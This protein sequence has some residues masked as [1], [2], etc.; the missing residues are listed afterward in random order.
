MKAKFQGNTRYFQHINNSL[1]A[2]FIGYIAADG[3]I[4][5]ITK[6]SKGLSITLHSIDRNV[7][8]LLRECI[9]CEHKIYILKN[10]LVRFQLCNKDLVQDL[11]KLGI[12]QRKTF[13]LRNIVLNIPKKFRKAFILG[14]FDGD[15]SVI[16]PTDCR[17]PNMNTKRICI[18]I[19]GTESFLLGIAKE[20]LLKQYS[21][22]K[23]DSTF[24][25]TFSKKTEI[26]KF[27]DCYN[28]SPF[29]LKRKYE[30]FLKRL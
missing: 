4:S 1:K 7:L 15:G 21:I 6:S 18:M 27:F 30:K 12:E 5:Q 13:T 8:D 20:L 17:K 3:C 10:N 11:E 19:R 23:Y 16:L 24:R 25:L 14:F 29:F 2:Y 9:G 28:H 26:L 22:K